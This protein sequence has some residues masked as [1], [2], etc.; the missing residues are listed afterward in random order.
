MKKYLQNYICCVKIYL[1]CM[2]NGVHDETRMPITNRG[3]EE[4]RYYGTGAIR[5]VS[6]KKHAE[7]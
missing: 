5:S 1:V 2:D 4:K 7:E 3:A 6:N